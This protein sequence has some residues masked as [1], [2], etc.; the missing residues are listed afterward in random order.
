MHDRAASVAAL[1]QVVRGRRRAL[2]LTQQETAELAGVAVRTVHAVEAGKTTVRLEAL[3]AILS[4]LGLQLVLE[5]GNS[6]VGLAI[7]SDT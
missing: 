1:G 5:R 2:T 4:A 7:G 3:L 6:G